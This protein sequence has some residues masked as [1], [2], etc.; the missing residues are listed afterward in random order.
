MLLVLL[1]CSPIP[2]AYAA[3]KPPPPPPGPSMGEVVRLHM[4]E[5]L[6]SAIST[7]DAVIRGDVAEAREQLEWMANNQD[8]GTSIEAGATWIEALRA[9][10]RAGYQGRSVTEYGMAVGREGAACAGC[11]QTLKAP[12]SPV[13]ASK[14]TDGTGHGKL[15]NWVVATMWTGL[16]ANSDAAWAN[17]AA[18][19]EALPADAAGYWV[20]APGPAATASMAVLKEQAGS[21]KSA[22]D[23]TSRGEAFGRVVGACGS[24][25][26]E[27]GAIK[28]Q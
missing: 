4:S 7:R 23:R 8:P 25:H 12:L 26:A 28:P 5:N 2:E 21:A 18:G 14:P 6:E 3:P 10:A 22:G 24:C 27:V 15:A 17:G 11:H 19:L 9:A 1:A 13:T 20:G 16:I